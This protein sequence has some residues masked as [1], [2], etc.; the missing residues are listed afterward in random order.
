MAEILE[1]LG[2]PVVTGLAFGHGDPN[3]AW[4]QGARAAID[5]A[6]GE[7]ELLEFGVGR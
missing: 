1:P 5:G 7:I 2:V 6:R 3:L 4:P